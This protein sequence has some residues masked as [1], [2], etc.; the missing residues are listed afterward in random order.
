[1]KLAIIYLVIILCCCGQS[2]HAQSAG[3]KK[4][5]ILN[6]ES[7][8]I[9][10]DYIVVGV[11]HSIPPHPLKRKDGYIYQITLSIGVSGDDFLWSRPLNCIFT[12]PDGNKVSK[13]IN[14]EGYTLFSNEKHH[15]TIDLH[16]KMKGQVKIDISPYYEFANHSPSDPDIQ[17]LG[18]YVYLE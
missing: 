3:D 1:M 7:R 4:I 14:T 5:T 2:M 15:F 6:A 17:F 11:T 8:F 13:V 16:C 12:F 10:D 18:N 9:D